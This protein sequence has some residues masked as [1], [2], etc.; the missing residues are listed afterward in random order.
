MDKKIEGNYPVYLANEKYGMRGL[1][2]RASSNKHGICLL[3]CSP[4]CNRVNYHQGLMRVGRYGDQCT[5]YINS[6]MIKEVDAIQSST[7]KANI[8]KDL[9]AIEA[10]KNSDESQD[11]KR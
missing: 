4:F 5:R 3:V 6:K 7:Y 1:D 2:Y 8:R 10:M 11:W 9:A